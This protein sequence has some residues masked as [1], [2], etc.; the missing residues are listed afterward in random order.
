MCNHVIS[1]S[2]AYI[3]VSTL[4]G[5]SRVLQPYQRELVEYKHFECKCMFKNVILDSNEYLIMSH[6]VQ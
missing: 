1:Y 4:Y 6:F 3:T 5:T 2:N